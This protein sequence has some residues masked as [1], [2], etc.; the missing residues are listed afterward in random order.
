[1]KVP[2]KRQKSER[3][4]YSHN[5]SNRQVASICNRV[6]QCRYKNFPD[7]PLRLMPL[8]RRILLMIYQFRVRVKLELGLVSVFMF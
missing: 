4:R 6:L 1:M 8:K 5:D 2:A 3:C 7:I